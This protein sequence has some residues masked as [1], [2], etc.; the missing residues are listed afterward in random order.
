MDQHQITMLVV[1]IGALRSLPP[2]VLCSQK[3]SESAAAAN[4]RS[5]YDRVVSKEGEVSRAEGVL[6]MAPSAGKSL[7]FVLSRA[8]AIRF[9]PTVGGVQAQFVDDPKG[10]VRERI[11]S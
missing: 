11:S 5:R 1:A 9:Q 8:H 2:S 7:N 3:T 4:A 10:A 6:A